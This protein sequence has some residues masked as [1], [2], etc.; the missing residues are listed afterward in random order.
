[1]LKAAAGAAAALVAALAAA[2]SR[3]GGKF[4]HQQQHHRAPRLYAL[5]WYVMAFILT[6]CNGWVAHASCNVILRSQESGAQ[7]VDPRGQAG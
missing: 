3:R 5:M 4:S 7:S 2:A 6:L 1:M